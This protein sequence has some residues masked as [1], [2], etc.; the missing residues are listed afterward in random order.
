MT[1]LDAAS[2]VQMRVRSTIPAQRT[3][4]DHL[5]AKFMDVHPGFVGVT[6]QSCARRTTRPR[7]R[8]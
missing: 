3:M 1:D 2:I 5:M 4:E 6:A 8:A 7:H